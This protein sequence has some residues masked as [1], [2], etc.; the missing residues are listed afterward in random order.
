MSYDPSYRQPPRQ[1]RWP[2]ATPAEGWPSYRDGDA[3]RGG[4]HADGRYGTGRHGAYPAAAGYQQQAGYQPGSG[5]SGD[6]GYQ[7][8]VVTDPFPPAGNGYGTAVGYGAAEGY[9]DAGGYA[10]ADGYG[11]AA[12]YGDAR[13]GYDWSP[14]GYGDAGNGNGYR[15]G[16]YA[17]GV[18][19]YAGGY[20]GTAGG[21]AS[22]ADAFDG[23][24][25]GYATAAD[26]YDLAGT[27]YGQ[28]TAEYPADPGGYDWN[29][30]GYGNTAYGYGNTAD[31]YAGTAGGYAGAQDDFAGGGY[32]GSD[33]YAEHGMSDP[34]LAAPDVGVHPGRWQADQER[35]REA[36]WRGPVTG[37]VSELLGI[38][39]VIGVS[40][41]AAGLFRAQASPISAMGS[42]FVDRM[43]AALRNAVLAH[44]GAHGQAVLLLGMYATIAV[45]ALAIGVLARRA[46]AL[47]MAGLAAFTLVVAFVAV[48]RPAGHAG[49]VAPAI[50]GGLAGAAALGWL[51]RASAPAQGIA[52]LRHARGGT[53]RRTR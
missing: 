29:E 38:A 14:D 21:Y 33:G 15:T 40:T 19:D 22:P 20:P 24:T 47:G 30:N 5:G 25:G 13:G 23:A 27:G 32:P 2:N 7:S 18:S 50:V 43:P 16:G 12:G 9:G 28:A 31:G 49:D 37:A 44:F 42:V 11:D 3:A 46:P 26:G 52:P 34:M 35:R 39:V 6:R 45:I 53:R 17:Q 10:T 4:E 1:E 8:A 48:T 41:L 36:S 51:V